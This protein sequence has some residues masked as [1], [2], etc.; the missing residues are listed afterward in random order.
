MCEYI[1]EKVCVREEEWETVVSSPVC[2][3]ELTVCER[4]V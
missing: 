4:T 1:N 3:A 2:L